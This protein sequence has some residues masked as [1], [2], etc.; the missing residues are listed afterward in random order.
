TRA[1]SPTTEPLAGSSSSDRRANASR[2]SDPSSEY[3][4]QP[5]ETSS[6]TASGSSR[7]T[8]VRTAASDTSPTRATS[9]GETRHAPGSSLTRSQASADA[10]TQGTLG[11][12]VRSSAT[13]PH[14]LR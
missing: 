3:R 14:A 5:S 2:D 12:D 8:A 11:V 6:T 7:T 10:T 1:T 13:D 9:P 4:V